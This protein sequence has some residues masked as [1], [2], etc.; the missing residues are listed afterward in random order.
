MYTSFDLNYER[1]ASLP[2]SYENIV[3]EW[4]LYD[5]FTHLILRVKATLFKQ[6]VDDV[7][8]VIG[9][10]FLLLRFGVLSELLLLEVDMF[11]LRGLL[12]LVV[13]YLVY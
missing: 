6:P 5:F 7:L 1:L 13:D 9:K 12:S 11:V 10:S 4:T 2:V 8:D 3:Y